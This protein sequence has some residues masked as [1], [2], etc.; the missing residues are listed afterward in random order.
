M[1]R[2]KR[3]YYQMGFYLLLSG[4]LLGGLAPVWPLERT[5]NAAPDLTITDDLGRVVTL[6]KKPGRVVIISTSLLDLYYGVGGKAVGRIASSHKVLTPEA[7]R[8]PVVGRIGLVDPEKLV[9]L[10]PDLIISLEGTGEKLIPVLTSNKLAIIFLRLKTYE[11]VRQKIK[12]FGVIAGTEGQAARQKRRLADRMRKITARLPAQSKKIVILHATAKSVTVEMENSLAGSIAKM[13]RLKNIAAGRKSIKGD[14]DATPYSLEQLVGGDPD[15]ILITVM[16]SM[17]NIER[18]IWADVK[19]NPAWA[20]LRAV[21]NRQVFFLPYQL[22]TF[23][24]GIHY[25]RSVAYLAKIAYPE[26]Y[27]NVK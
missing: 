1:L 19:A 18:R 5:V 24:P 15:L 8:L 2:W 22:F 10:Q 27:A 13:L 23:N 14:P 21:R 20:S 26:V 6:R 4:M 7:E 17:A 3:I 16:G 25:D 11:D 12:L 9:A